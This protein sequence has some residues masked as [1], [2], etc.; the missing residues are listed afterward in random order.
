MSVGFEARRSIQT[1]LRAR[2]C[3]NE[4]RG[5]T[6]GTT[7][8]CHAFLVRQRLRGVAVIIPASVIRPQPINRLHVFRLHR[9]A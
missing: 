2:C 6:F 9:G 8:W 5:I 1:E 4:L 3:F 7:F